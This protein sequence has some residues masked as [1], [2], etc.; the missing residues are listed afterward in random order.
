MAEEMRATTLT[1][2]V[3]AGRGRGRGANISISA[4]MAKGGDG[5]RAAQA[6]AGADAQA[7]SGAAP[8]PISGTMAA[9][10]VALGCGETAGGTAACARPKLPDWGIMTK[11]Q[12]RHWHKRQYECGGGFCSL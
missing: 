10:A 9:K 12:R 3:A 4:L 6:A 8:E 11:G 1:S 5:P 2:A 7:E